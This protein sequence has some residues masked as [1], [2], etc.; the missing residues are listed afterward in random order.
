MDGPVRILGV[1]NGDPAYKEDERPTDRNARTYH[2][3]TFNGLAQI[4]L[5][6]DGGTGTA[7][8]TVEGE[9]IGASTREITC[10]R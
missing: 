8:L 10:A 6:S 7:T 5:Q 1:G 9:G 4:L 3:K 2:V